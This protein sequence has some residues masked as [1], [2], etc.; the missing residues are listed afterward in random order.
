[1]VAV[2]LGWLILSERVTPATLV[3]AALVVGSVAAVVRHE[4]APR[5]ETVP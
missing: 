1:V 3:G 4:S 2:A 5:P